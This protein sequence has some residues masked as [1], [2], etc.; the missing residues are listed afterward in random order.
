MMEKTI[1]YCENDGF[2]K[3]HQPLSGVAR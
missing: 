1:K 3:P 2:F